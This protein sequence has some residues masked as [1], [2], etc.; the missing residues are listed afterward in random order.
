MRVDD[1][2]YW[3]NSFAKEIKCK[4][5]EEKKGDSLRKFYV[6]ALCE[7]AADGRRIPFY[8][9]KGTDD[10]VWAHERG[11]IKEKELIKKECSDNSD[12]YDD[13][14]KE[15]SDKYKKIGQIK[16]EGNEIEKIIVK[17]G[18]TEYE[19]FMC[20][21]TLINIFEMQ[22][23]VYDSN[24][25]QLTNIVNGHASL[26][27]KLAGIETKARPVDE[28]APK[29]KKPLVINEIDEE[30]QVVK[31]KRILLQNIKMSFPKCKNNKDIRDSVSGNWVLKSD[32]LNPEYVFAI[33]QSRIE[34]VYK[35]RT[36]HGRQVHPIYD[37]DTEVYPKNEGL[38]FKV[39]DYK[40]AEAIVS[41]LKIKKQLSGEIGD[42]K[43]KEEARKHAYT[44]L[45]PEAKK[46]VEEDA[47]F[48][49]K[50]ETVSDETVF[51]NRVLKD[52][53]KETEK[54]KKVRFME[55]DEDTV[56]EMGFSPNEKKVIMRKILT[57]YVQLLKNS[58][59]PQNVVNSLFSKLPVD[60][61]KEFKEFYF[62]NKLNNWFDRKYMVLDDIESE[63]DDKGNDIS[64]NNLLHSE[65][66][67]RMNGKDVKI[68][69]CEGYKSNFQ[70]LS[71]MLFIE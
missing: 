70:P 4:E 8:I 47:M 48:D 17:C 67:I 44:I 37:F 35:V 19:A 64:L 6:Y 34:G 26:F 2:V 38:D 62:N 21:S 24:E 15:L 7:R 51:F 10:R 28:F 31:G 43:L 29:C 3:I 39:R 69:E 1:F 25:S 53:I 41:G 27:E 12:E 23:L 56:K 40:Y 5:D 13:R 46:V 18:L 71:K 49:E 59:N 9:G 52:M 63:F 20:E 58:S 16:A 45:P 55:I 33:N 22:G 36:V 30:Y 50:S 66:C 65:I 60:Y 68:A 32:C 54:N 61:K 57:F 11:E 42:I 14:V